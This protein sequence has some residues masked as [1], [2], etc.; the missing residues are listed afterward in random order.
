MVTLVTVLALL[1]I[2]AVPYL[3]ARF[4][5]ARRPVRVAPVPS[6]EL[7]ATREFARRLL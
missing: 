3:V 7:L 1:L 6:A 4:R 2:V 5:K